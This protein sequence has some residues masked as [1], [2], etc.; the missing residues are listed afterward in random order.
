MENLVKAFIQYLRDEKKLSQNTL[1]SYQR[2]IE[3]Y[4]MFLQEMNVNN[5]QQSTKTTVSTYVKYQNS[6]EELLLRYQEALH[7]FVPFT[8]F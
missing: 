6:Q 7:P 8:D 3:Q 2:D 5:I 4:I 1:L